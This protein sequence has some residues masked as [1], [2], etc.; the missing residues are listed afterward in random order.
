MS[1][2]RRSQPQLQHRYDGVAK[3]TGKAKYAAEF[4]EP[5]AKADL[6]YALIV[7]STIPCGTI[8]SI[9]RTAAERA[10]GV[11]AVL[12]PF[13][14]P[15]LTRRQPEPPARR[16]LTR[17]AGHGCALQRAADRAGRCDDAGAGAVRGDAAEDQVQRRS[18]RSWTSEA[19][20]LGE[21]RW[22]KNPG[23]EPPANHRGDMEAGLRRLR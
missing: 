9:D 4:A 22:P 16:N 21:A 8:A 18:R 19:S 3:V 23:K 14:A 17:A 13:N 12:T 15:K 6:V 5:F 10:A 7:Q 20:D 1:A 11:L 2:E